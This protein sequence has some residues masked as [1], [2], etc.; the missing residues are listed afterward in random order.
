MPLPVS[1]RAIKSTLENEREPPHLPA[2]QPTE[3]ALVWAQAPGWARPCCGTE[4]AVAQV[5]KSGPTAAQ[6]E[7]FT[8]RVRPPAIAVQ[9]EQPSFQ[10]ISDGGRHAY[11]EKLFEGLN[12]S[13][14]EPAFN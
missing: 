13:Q 12:H 1:A 10:V 11:A 2:S 7:A 3:F 6:G 4:P 14:T 8:D 5:C 9:R